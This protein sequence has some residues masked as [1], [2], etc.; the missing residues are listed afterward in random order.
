MS[1]PEPTNTTN[2][3]LEYSNTAEA[4]EIISKAKFMSMIDIIK[5]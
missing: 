5:K 3:N 4:Q 2:A 1:S